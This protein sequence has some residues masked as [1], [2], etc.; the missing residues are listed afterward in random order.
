MA[1]VLLSGKVIGILSFC[2]CPLLCLFIW[3]INVRL[4][5]LRASRDL[6][7]L[8]NLQFILLS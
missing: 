8:V 3:R 6:R 5:I 7:S 2:L 4:Y 1:L